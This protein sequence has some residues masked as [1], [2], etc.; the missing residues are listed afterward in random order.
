MHPG[1]SK[2]RK[3]NWSES[4]SSAFISIQLRS[5]FFIFA[6]HIYTYIQVAMLWNG[7]LI[8]EVLTLPYRGTSVVV[9][10]RRRGPDVNVDLREISLNLGLYLSTLFL[11]FPRHQQFYTIHLSSRYTFSARIYEQSAPRAIAR[12]LA[13]EESRLRGPDTLFL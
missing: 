3:K 11:L 7:P 12:A 10:L 8:L 6:I 13:T 5:S 2:K 1:V 4:S 9:D